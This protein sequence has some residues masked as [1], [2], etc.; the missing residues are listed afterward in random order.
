MKNTGMHL[1][2]VLVPPIVYMLFVRTLFP[3]ALVQRTVLHISTYH[4]IG[5]AAY[6]C[7]MF[8]YTLF[9]WT[10]HT[11]VPQ[12]CVPITAPL[13]RWYMD[14]WY[15]SKMWEWVDTA[16]LLARGKQLSRLHTY[17]H[18]TTASLVALQTLWRSTSHPPAIYELGTAWNAGVHAWMYAYYA[19]PRH[20]RGTRKWLTGF[21]C[22]QHLYM[23]YTLIH[24]LSAECTDVDASG[25]WVGLFM[26]L[27]FLIEFTSLFIE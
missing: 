9:R 2:H 24:S 20:M 7:F 5:L 11:G 19:F 10:F 16:V 8:A 1:T 18:A 15:M 14:S 27:F 21:Q 6:S 25:N 12:V 17:H 22:L 4:N 13:P 23:V 26:Y 3:L